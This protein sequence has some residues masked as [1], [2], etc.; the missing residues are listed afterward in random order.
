MRFRELRELAGSSLDGGDAED[1][2]IGE[3]KEQVK[4][5]ELRARL[6]KHKDEKDTAVISIIVLQIQK[7]LFT[8]ANR[9]LGPMICNIRAVLPHLLNPDDLVASGIIHKYQKI[10]ERATPVPEQSTLPQ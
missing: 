2:S 5:L 10:T 1:K 8:I 7:F 9:T 3:L 6:C 4:E